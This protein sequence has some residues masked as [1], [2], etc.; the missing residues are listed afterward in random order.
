MPRRKMTEAALAAA[1][2]MPKIP[3]EIIEQFVG[4]PMTA[5]AVQDTFMVFKKALIE[6]AITGH[7]L[8][9][10]FEGRWPDLPADLR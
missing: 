10:H 6:R 4:G 1:V 7:V 8:C 5:E 9:W 3:K 2:R